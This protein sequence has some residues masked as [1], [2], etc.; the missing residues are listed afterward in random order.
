MPCDELPVE[1]RAVF[2]AK[3][4]RL[5]EDILNL[6]SNLAELDV[7]NYWKDASM[8]TDDILRDLAREVGL[9]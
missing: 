1:I 2:C 5:G 9:D 4:G 8:L 3:K 6:R 7:F